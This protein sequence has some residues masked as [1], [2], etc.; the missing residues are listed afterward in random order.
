MALRGRLASVAGERCRLEAVISS[1][2]PRVL[3]REV[4]RVATI[5]VAVVCL[6]TGCQNSRISVEAPT[7]IVVAMPS[8]EP[9]VWDARG[10]IVN[11][12]P[13]DVRP[14]IAD[15]A[16][17][18]RRATY[19]SVSGLT[20]V[21]TEVS[22][23]FFTPKGDPPPGGW[24]VL[25]VAH[26]FTGTTSNCSPSSQAD[27]REYFGLVAA[28]LKSGFAVAFTDY[29]G[30]GRP[31]VH[32]FLEPRTAGFN[33]IDSVRALRALFPATGTRW[34]AFGISQG[35]QASWSAAELDGFYGNGLELLGATAI[36]PAANMAGMARLSYLDGLTP[37]QRLIMPA[38]IMGAERSRPPVPVDRLLHGTAATE[39][40]TAM[41]C[42]PRADELRSKLTNADLK[43]DTEADAVALE[44]SLRKMSLPTQ[45]LSVPLYV[46]NGSADDLV[47]PSWVA[48]SVSRACA[49]GGLIEHRE[50]AGAGHSVQPDEALSNWVT[51]RFTGKPAPT[52]CAAR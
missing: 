7:P 23:A 15:A 5:L 8:I 34:V 42:T 26:G 6:M 49:I 22:G 14:E 43:P 31:G 50:I 1:S 3:G 45:P 17:Q 18:V 44:T 30:L 12:E 29:E 16:G 39:V 51:D 9:A 38:L 48:T 36:A 41:D 20:G 4:I 11:D 24:P 52:N 32:P 27:L 2:T 21:P 46:L 19:R 37:D 35:G 33:V 13:F 28:L 40:T 25:G 10:T 47:L